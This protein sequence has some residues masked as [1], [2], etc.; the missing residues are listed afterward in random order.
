MGAKFGR[1]VRS[2]H[3][4]KQAGVRSRM[5]G[6]SDRQQ[7]GNEMKSHVISEWT[8]AGNTRIGGKRMHILGAGAS[9]N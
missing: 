3:P 7:E 1:A 5:G 9:V 6:W 4:M 2:V 8:N